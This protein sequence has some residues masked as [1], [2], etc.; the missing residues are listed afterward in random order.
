MMALTLD[1]TTAM[2]DWVRE[3]DRMIVSVGIAVMLVSGLALI[4]IVALRQRERA[5]Q[6]YPLRRTSRCP[7]E[8]A[9]SRLCSGRSWRARWRTHA[10]A[11]T[12]HCCTSTWTGS[13]R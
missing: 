13:R 10:P 1:M 8:A 3:R 12:W 2:A 5:E 4:L 7:D 9:Q 6:T 11:S